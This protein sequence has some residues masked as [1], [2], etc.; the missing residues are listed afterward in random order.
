M[1]IRDRICGVEHQQV[2]VYILLLPGESVWACG[3][4]CT[5][6]FEPATP[7]CG[8]LCRDVYKRQV[9]ACAATVAVQASVIVIARQHSL[10]TSD[11]ST[12]R[13]D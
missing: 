9:A 11:P 7:D 13:C 2:E 3:D 10:F 4:D 8:E 12:V 1:C 6:I 5:W